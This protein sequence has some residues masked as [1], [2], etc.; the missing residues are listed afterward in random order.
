M[1]K[2]SWT[3]G[4]WGWGHLIECQCGQFIVAIPHRCNN[5]PWVPRSLDHSDKRIA[6]EE[7]REHQCKLAQ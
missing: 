7:Y 2:T 1:Y 6:D 5:R 3:N 4:P